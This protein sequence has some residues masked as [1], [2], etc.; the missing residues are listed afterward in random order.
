MSKNRIA[1]SVAILLVAVSLVMAGVLLTGFFTHLVKN[2]TVTDQTVSSGYPSESQTITGIL[3]SVGMAGE[4]IGMANNL[5]GLNA[6][7]QVISE[8]KLPYSANQYIWGNFSNPE[9]EAKYDA[10]TFNDSGYCV[11][12]TTS[13]IA[14]PLP[15]A[16]YVQSMPIIT[17]S[18]FTLLEDY[19]CYDENSDLFPSQQPLVD[20]P[21][22]TI[23][24]VVLAADRPSYEV[25][26]DYKITLPWSG[27]LQI[28]YTDVSGL[29]HPPEMPTDIYIVANT[30]EVAKK[31][32]T[33]KRHGT[34]VTITGQ[35]VG[36]FA[37]TTIIQVNNIS[38][39]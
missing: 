24:T 31:L 26:Y 3:R 27:A 25:G 13:A 5:H 8:G 9:V 7:F 1:V 4:E 30:L 21:M 16:E 19:S 23:T 29:D 32:E 18:D 22:V 36:G 28:G 20:L 6:R 11:S 12:V 15:Q 14:T 39:E 33:A 34:K 38:T 35:V 17:L 2:K 37:E 10:L